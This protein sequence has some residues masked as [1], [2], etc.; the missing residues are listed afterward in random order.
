LFIEEVGAFF[1]KRDQER[2]FKISSLSGC[3]SFLG[4]GVCET[5]MV[6]LQ[7]L[8]L[9]EDMESHLIPHEKICKHIY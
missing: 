8:I 3:L 9:E 5:A 7:V 6:S 2:S 4:S 1:I